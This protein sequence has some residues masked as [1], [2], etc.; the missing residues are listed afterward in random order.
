MGLVIQK[1]IEME[2]NG[3]KENGSKKFILQKIKLNY[4]IEKANKPI[5]L[6]Y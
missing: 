5:K 4:I 1:G 3:M 6:C 2:W